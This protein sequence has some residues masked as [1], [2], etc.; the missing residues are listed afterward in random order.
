MKKR[1]MSLLIAIAMLF[2][3]VP[4]YAHATTST[5]TRYEYTFD[6]CDILVEYRLVNDTIVETTT[7]A[8]QN[9]SPY[10]IEKK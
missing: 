10:I 5:Y 8:E 3:F 9:N 7:I 2:Q 4:F 6:T 1:F